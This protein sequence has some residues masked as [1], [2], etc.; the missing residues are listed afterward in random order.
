MAR[1]KRHYILGQICHQGLMKIRKNDIVHENTHLWVTKNNRSYYPKE[2]RRRFFALPT[3]AVTPIWAYELSRSFRRE[4]ITPLKNLC[5]TPHP[6][7]RPRSSRFEGSHP[8][9]PG[10]DSP[11]A[12][13]LRQNNSGSPGAAGDPPTGERPYRHART[14]PTGGRCG[15]ALDGPGFGGKNQPDV[16]VIR[17]VST[18][19]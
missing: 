13:R 2:G 18:V 11:G 3:I 19:G 15:G 6:S 10:G 4:T 8:R 14:A 5:F 1:A 7:H 17:S 9:P 16:R 12:A